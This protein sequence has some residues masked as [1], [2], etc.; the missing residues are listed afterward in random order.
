MTQPHA[1]P[2]LRLSLLPPALLL[3]LLAVN[4]ALFRDDASAGPN[5]AALLLAA[6]LT[7][8]LGRFVLKMPYREFETRAIK[9]IVL[10]ME[11][12]LI[13]LVVGALIGLWI[14]A[15]IVPTMIA[16]GVQA[17]HPAVFPLVAC[18][19]CSV[20]SLAIGSSWSTMG[21]VGIA[22]IG[23]G[24]ALGF[25][26][27]LVAGAVVSG[28]YFGDKMSPLS[29]TTNLAPAAA[30]VELFTHIRN[31]LHTTG[32]AYAITLAAFAGIG[33]LYTPG[34]LDGA[35]V[36]DIVAGIAAQFNV[37]AWLLLVP[38]VVILLAA[39]K[40]PAVPALVVGALLGAACA[41][42]AQPQRLLGDT[43]AFSAANAYRALL[44]TAYN[45]HTLA[46]GNAAVDALLS[47]GGMANMFDTIS[48]IIT[49]MLFGG[50]MESTGMLPRIADAILHWVRGAA[51]LIGATVGTCIVFNILAAE[52]YLAI[53][54][55]GRMFR[56]AYRQYG[57]DPRNLS[58]ALED[59]ATVT[60]VLVPWNTCGAFAASVLGVPTLAYLPYA[61]FNLLCPIVSIAMASMRLA[62]VQ[63][64]PTHDDPTPATP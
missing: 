5:Q 58:R 24:G 41:I 35:A 55:P 56:P 61:F 33:L 42:V 51:S 7:G 12:I 37:S 43:G 45:G 10:A 18:L 6:M 32:P 15:G 14:L 60:S 8:L 2:S 21:T 38:G 17:I 59:G 27:G 4:V 23:I 64:L 30:G 48:L 54:V 49:A 22:L 39:R 20:V 52:Q 25:P 28:A 19:V 34:A 26:L 13:L 63:A 57:L 40:V 1:R 50:M 31:M 29:D 53:V 46:S 11:A 9:S 47:R 16:Y 62:I 3:A 36:D 44:D